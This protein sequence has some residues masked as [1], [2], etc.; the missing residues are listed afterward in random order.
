MS[1]LTTGG[2]TCVVSS[3]LPLE[4]PTA[5]M[6]QSG[7]ILTRDVSCGR[8]N[9]HGGVFAGFTISPCGFVGATAFGTPAEL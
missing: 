5:G 8:C 2:M 7:I 1:E 3:S 4:D 6:I 9:H